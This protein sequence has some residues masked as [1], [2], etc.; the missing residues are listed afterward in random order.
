MREL[1][2][3]HYIILTLHWA[4]QE[5]GNQMSFASNVEEWQQLIKNYANIDFNFKFV[6]KFC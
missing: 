3:E 4:E 1:H 2:N 5:K 6:L